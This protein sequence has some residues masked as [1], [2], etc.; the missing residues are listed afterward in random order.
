MNLLE[1]KRLRTTKLIP[2]LYPL[3]GL[4]MHTMLCI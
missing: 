4:R 3:E 2:R 1:L